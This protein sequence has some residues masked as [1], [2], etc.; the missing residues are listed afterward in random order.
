MSFASGGGGRRA[1]SCPTRKTSELLLKLGC[2]EEE[3]GSTN[4]WGSNTS[5]KK[6]SNLQQHVCVFGRLPTEHQRIKNEEVFDVTSETCLHVFLVSV[7]EDTL[8]F[9]H[10]PKHKGR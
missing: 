9:A 2:G 7:G 4:E 10:W 3:E 8:V 5:N 6:C 1:S